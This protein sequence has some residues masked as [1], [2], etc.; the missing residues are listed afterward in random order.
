MEVESGNG[1]LGTIL[2]NHLLQILSYLGV[3]VVVAIAIN[4][5]GSST[6]ALST[7]ELLVGIGIAV[8]AGILC[9]FS[10]YST[11][12]YFF[13]VPRSS[14][15]IDL[16]AALHGGQLS[17]PLLTSIIL[18][19]LAMCIMV[20][21]LYAWIA[22]GALLSVFS[23]QTGIILVK[24]RSGH[25]AMDPQCQMNG[26]SVFY[27]LFQLLIGGE[28]ITIVGG[29][30]PIS[31]H[32]LHEMPENTW[33]IDVR[34]RAEYNWSRLYTAESFPF[35]AGV[36]AAAQNR[37]KDTP[38]LVVCLSGH[39]SPGVALLLKRLGFESVY[40]LNWGMVYLMMTR[41]KKDNIE[42]PFGLIRAVKS[43]K[44]RISTS[45]R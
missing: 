1:V 42:G 28:M 5:P 39:R 18:G 8:L 19:L 6:S 2:Q 26:K 10:L 38:V 37:P 45:S 27:Q 14:R 4:F 11:L 43:Y 7:I 24:V 16:M 30:Q 21:S 41:L 3:V 31:P 40:N 33:I 15:A 20:G 44:H 35:G 25:L 34:T 32:R 9:F 17:H 13:L 12:V 23:L 36:L 29:A 22:F